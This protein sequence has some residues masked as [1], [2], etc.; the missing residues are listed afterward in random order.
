MCS[1]VLQNIE[2]KKGELVQLP[3][4]LKAHS[5]RAVGWQSGG[6]GGRAGALDT[7]ARHRTRPP[8]TDLTGQSVFDAFAFGCLALRA[9]YICQTFRSL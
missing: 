9:A 1:I 2:E 7:R 5:S 6:G 3:E 4:G 8:P